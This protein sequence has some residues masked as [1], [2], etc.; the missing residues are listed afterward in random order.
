MQLSYFNYSVFKFCVIDSDIGY[1]ACLK[2]KQEGKYIAITLP[3]QVPKF[4]LPDIKIED[5]HNFLKK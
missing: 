2:G 3:H 5:S 4:V 1:R